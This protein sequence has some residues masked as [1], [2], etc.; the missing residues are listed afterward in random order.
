[1]P[2]MMISRAMIDLLRRQL[3]NCLGKG[4]VRRIEGMGDLFVTLG[5]DHAPSPEGY[6]FLYSLRIDEKDY[7]F[8]GK[9]R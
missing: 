2:G 3:T 4:E 9:V 7:N 8:L 5:D 6:H 1:M